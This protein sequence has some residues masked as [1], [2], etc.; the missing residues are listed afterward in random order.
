MIGAEVV[1]AVVQVEVLRGRRRQRGFLEQRE[2]FG[3]EANL[4]LVVEEV[5]YHLVHR[6]MLRNPPP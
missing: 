4:V 1:D 2:D 3:V 6:W 5:V